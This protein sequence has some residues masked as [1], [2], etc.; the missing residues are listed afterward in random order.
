[1]VANKIAPL[2][3][4]DALPQLIKDRAEP[5]LSSHPSCFLWIRFGSRYQPW[6]D[7][8]EFACGQLMSA[9]KHAGIRPILIGS[10]A[11]Y[12]SKARDNL[13]GFYEDEPYR[14]DPLMQ[15][16]LLD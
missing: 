13:I 10:P 9:L 16:R 1:L 15:L 8:T 5:L 2:L 7:L 4:E 12:L 11:A 6:R 3:R 14:K